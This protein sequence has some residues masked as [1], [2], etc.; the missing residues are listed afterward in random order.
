ML[1]ILDAVGNMLHLSGGDPIEVFE[2][3]YK[4]Q[5]RETEIKFLSK[6]LLKEKKEF[7]KRLSI[8][9]DAL[10]GENLTHRARGLL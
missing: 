5:E 6:E 8:N 9:N 3:I 1:S 4:K 10:H 7:E 2:L